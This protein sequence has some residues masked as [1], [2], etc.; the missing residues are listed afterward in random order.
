MFVTALR[1]CPLSPLSIKVFPENQ[2][3]SAIYPF[4]PPAMLSS[5][6]RRLF[7]AKERLVPPDLSGGGV[8]S[9]LYLLPRQYVCLGAYPIGAWQVRRQYS[10]DQ[11]YFGR[12]ARLSFSRSRARWGKGVTRCRESQEAEY[13]IAK[14][15]LGAVIAE[16]ENVLR[17]LRELQGYGA[18]LGQGFAYLAKVSDPQP[19]EW[20]DMVCNPLT[21]VR[22]DSWTGGT[23]AAYPL[24]RWILAGVPDPKPESLDP[25]PVVGQDSAY[26][27]L[28]QGV[29]RVRGFSLEGHFFSRDLYDFYAEVS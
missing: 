9:A 16:E 7:W 1:I 29:G 10:S 13:L 3:G 24:F 26:F 27:V 20:V 11:I 25:S 6:L 22:A 21:P 14:I 15:F 8:S 18:E 5:W 17:T 28:T 19:V 4:I 2:L 23:R 12:P